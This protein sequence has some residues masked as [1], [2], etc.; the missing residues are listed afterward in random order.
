LAGDVV[1]LSGVVLADAAGHEE[2]F[3]EAEKG[4]NVGPK[5]DE[6]EDAE[7]V[8]TEI[9]VMDAEA[10][11]KESEEDADDLILVGALVFGVKPAALLVVH[12]GGVDRVDGVHGV[13]PLEEILRGKG[14]GG[15][16]LGWA[17]STNALWC[18]SF[19]GTENIPHGLKPFF[20]FALERAKP[21][22]LAYLEADR[23]EV[24]GIEQVLRSE[25][26]RTVWFSGGSCLEG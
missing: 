22:G 7:A 16:R 4:G 20:Y 8:A 23:S 18:L 3:D 2:T 11:E 21:E 13:G 5:E 9:E 24:A 25:H 15:S 14:S 26:L 6:V 10:A 12:V 17:M 1:S 19:H